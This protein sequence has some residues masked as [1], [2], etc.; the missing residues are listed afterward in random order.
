[1]IDDLGVSNEGLANFEIYPNPVS[2]KIGI[3][4]GS[5][6][7]NKIT[8]ELIDARSRVV[9][10]IEGERESEIWLILPLN[11]EE[12]VYFLRASDGNIVQSRKIIVKP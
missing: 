11:I 10:K 2:D 6:W 3:K 7:S 12:A 4:L 1:V 5:E 9:M 8:I